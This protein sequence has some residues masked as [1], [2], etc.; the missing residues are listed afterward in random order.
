[1]VFFYIKDILIEESF[2]GKK[3]KGHDI[4]IDER[5]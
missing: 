3:S 1:M 4:Y 2:F 5:Q